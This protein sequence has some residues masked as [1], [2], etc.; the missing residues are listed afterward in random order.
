[1]GAEFPD[2]GLD[3]AVGDDVWAR[4]DP[5]A[6]ARIV[7]VL[8]DNALAHGAPP[9]RLE[10]ARDAGGHA[11]LV[12]TDS[13]PG[14]PAHERERIFGRFERAG[15]GV[16]PGFGLGLAIA[17]GLARRMG[18]DVRA[19]DGSRFVVTLPLEPMTSVMPS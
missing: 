5:G 8:L 18:G 9:V 14:V 1:M 12:V 17:R 3:L 15:D 2:A 4:A 16:T 6:V 10:I 19:E 11:S 13:G 7:R